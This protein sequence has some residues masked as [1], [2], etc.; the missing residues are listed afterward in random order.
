MN[1]YSK[2]FSFLSVFNIVFITFLVDHRVVESGYFQSPT[3]YND[4]KILK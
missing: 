4:K 2:D 1:I 3:S